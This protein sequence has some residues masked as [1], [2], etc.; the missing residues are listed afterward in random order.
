MKYTTKVKQK[1]YVGKVKIG[2]KGG[3][4]DDVQKKEILADPWGKELVKKGMLIIEGV[5]PEDV[6]KHYAASPK[7]EAPK[8]ADLSGEPEKD[9][10][11]N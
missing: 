5:R 4:L 3:D 9:G 6:D 11:N 10:K 8:Q 1:Q 2:P 7:K